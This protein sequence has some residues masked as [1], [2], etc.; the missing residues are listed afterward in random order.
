[1]FWNGTNNKKSLPRSL[2]QRERALWPGHRRR[3]EGEYLGFCESEVL[4]EI[5]ALSTCHRLSFPR[6]RPTFSVAVVV[7]ASDTSVVARI[8][9]GL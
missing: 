4:C 2:V 8:C 7:D 5:E 6:L 3:F 9:A 1:M